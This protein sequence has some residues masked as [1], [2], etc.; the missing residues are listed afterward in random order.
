[1][2]VL[3]PDVERM[4]TR[5]NVLVVDG[6]TVVVGGQ[7]LLGIGVGEASRE[8]VV[9]SGVEAQFTTVH[10]EVGEVDVGQVGQF[11]AR[12]FV[13]RRRCGNFVLHVVVVNRSRDVVT[14]FGVFG[15][16]RKVVAFF[17]TKVGRALNNPNAAHVEVVI[18]LLQRW[19]AKAHAVAQTQR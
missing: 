1:M 14:R 3:G 13:I 16:E 6:I 8:A 2:F 11:V 17:G 12:L 9:P 4:C 18:P 5:R 7:L 19:A 10:L 15:R